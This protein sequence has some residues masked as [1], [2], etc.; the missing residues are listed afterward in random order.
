MYH[1]M[2]TNQTTFER[3]NEL[4]REGFTDAAGFQAR[5]IFV[6]TYRKVG[7]YNMRTDK[8]R[9]VWSL[10]VGVVGFGPKVDVIGCFG[11]GRGRVE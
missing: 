2:T 6:T 8:V 1:H 7:Y 11:N 5:K 10:Y 3:A 4:I 9:K